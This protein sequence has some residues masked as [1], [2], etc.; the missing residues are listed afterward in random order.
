[1]KVKQL[2]PI[3]FNAEEVRIC[4]VDKAVEWCG[5]AY[6]IPKK[7]HKANID[8]VCSFPIKDSDSCTYIYIKSK[9]G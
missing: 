8:K 5:Y 9:K 6:S 1:M 4:R 7:Y 2:L 3:L